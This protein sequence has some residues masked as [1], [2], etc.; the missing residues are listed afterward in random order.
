MASG[1]QAGEDGMRGWDPHDP[2]RAGSVEQTIAFAGYAAQ[3]AS[4]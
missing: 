3:R 4:T 2:P 1:N